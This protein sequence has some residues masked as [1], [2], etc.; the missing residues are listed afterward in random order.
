MGESHT[1]SDL[2]KEVNAPYKVLRPHMKTGDAI[3]WQG[4]YLISRAIRCFSK[5]S[6]VSMVLRLGNEY[7]MLRDRVFLVEALEG[8]LELRSLSQRLNEYQGK[9]FWFETPLSKRQQRAAGAYSLHMVSKGIKYDYSS[10]FANL[11][12]RVSSDARKYFCSEFY[13]DVMKH[14]GHAEYQ[15]KAP[16]PGDIPEWIQG[17]TYQ[18]Y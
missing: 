1:S 7:E 9:A 18:I 16:R 6:H 10:L 11:L 5:Y 2:Q 3:L 17:V 12:G 14:V 4:D 15:E 8:G 13:H